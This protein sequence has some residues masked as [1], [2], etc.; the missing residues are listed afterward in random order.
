M[1]LVR[2]SSVRCRTADAGRR[3]QETR[4]WHRDQHQ[5]QHVGEE[6]LRLS[7]RGVLDGLSMGEGWRCFS[8]LTV[9]VIFSWTTTVA[10]L[11]SSPQGTTAKG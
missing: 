4:I 9:D 3:P 7:R 1:R 5:D 2:G 11:D 10:C 8:L 6:A